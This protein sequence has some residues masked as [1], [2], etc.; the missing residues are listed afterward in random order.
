METKTFLL[1]THEG[2]NM[3]KVVGL[4]WIMLQILA[5]N[6]SGMEKIASHEACRDRA[7]G[8]L[9]W[10]K[11]EVPGA[12]YAQVAGLAANFL[13]SVPVEPVSGLKLYMVHADFNGPE[14]DENYFKG[15]SGTD[16][17]PNPACVFAGFVQS[18]AVDYRVFSGD[19]SYLGLVRECLDQ[20]LENGTTPQDWP[21][22]GCPY[23]SADPRSPIYQGATHW[24]NLRRGDGLHCLE[25]DK[26]GELGA[27]YLKFYEITGEDKYLAAAIRCADALA[28]NVREVRADTNRFAHEFDSRSPWPF[29][30]NARTGLVVDEYSSNVVEPVRLLDELV[31]IAGR[32]GLEKGKAEAYLKAREIA[33]SWL[34]AKN[35]PLK[36]YIWNGY[37]EDIPSDPKLLNR[38]QITP[39]E[40]AR[41]ILRHP[42]YDPNWRKDVPA[43]LHWVASVFATDSLDAIKEQT[44]CFAPMGSHTARYASVCALYYEMSGDE[45]YKEEARR[46]FNFATYMCEDN[47][48]VWVGPGW[49]T[50]W[51]S[52]GYGDYIKHFMEGLGA[53]P[54][55]APAG[56]DHLLR[57]TSIVRTLACQPRRISYT[58]FDKEATEVLR[59]TG[60]PVRI[61][62]GSQPLNERDRLDGPGW[63]WN[64][65][66]SGGILRISHLGG[67]DIS[68]EK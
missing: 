2:G 55:W 20:M 22:P 37:F 68:I 36:T 54:E 16:W 46:F 53:V 11:P 34:F 66:K 47:G 49:P 24:E 67:T 18:L 25:P 57:S 8:L 43:L 19:D 14:Q 23:A 62:V 45:L 59:L 17:M 13:K 33:W 27:G 50:A 63:T 56:E 35:G 3:N 28:A 44:W 9:A 58:T 48:Y 61:T 21:W 30:V 38:V 40:T 29:R 12:A 4:F 32:T 65:L 10:Y 64:K 7:G 52:D 15:T 31:R 5:G 60:K 41:Y 26:V 42:E 6:L 39:L 51:F 1:I